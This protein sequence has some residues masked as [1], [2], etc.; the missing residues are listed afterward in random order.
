MEGIVNKDLKSLE[1]IMESKFYNKTK[2]A[3]QSLEKD[4]IALE[5]EE[6]DG[7]KEAYSADKYF[8]RGVN[9]DRS[10]NGNNFDYVVDDQHLG[11]GFRTYKHRFISQLT[12]QNFQ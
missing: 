5:L 8:V 1:S 3:M 12:L 11:D 4:G 10:K 6:N 7:K 2:G 9:V